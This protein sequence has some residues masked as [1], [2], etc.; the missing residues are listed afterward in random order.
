MGNKNDASTQHTSRAEI[1]K[2]HMIGK[3][4]LYIVKE[5]GLS[6]NVKILDYKTAYGKERYLAT[7]ISGAGQVWV[8]SVYILDKLKKR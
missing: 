8:Q 3:T 1:K 7:P 4:A 5:Y 2:H 6:L